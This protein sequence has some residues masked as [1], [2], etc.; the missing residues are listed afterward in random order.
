LSE[1][2]FTTVEGINSPIPERETMPVTSTVNFATRLVSGFFEWFGSLGIFSWQVLRAAVTPPF[3]GRELI[4]Q[5]DEVG[6]KSLPLVALAGAAIGAVLSMETNS[7]L[8][9]FGARSMLP[10]VTV[11]SLIVEMGPMITGLIVS[12]RVGA[13]I[14][15][16]LASMKVTEQIDAIEASAI[17]PYRLLAAT[18][19][20][21]CILMLPLLTLAADASGVLMGWV[22][23][24]L[25]EPVSL[26]RFIDSGF[27]GA[28]FN[29]FL[30]PTFKTAVFGLIIG[31]IACFQGMR[32]RGGAEGVGRA[33][34][35]AVVLSSLF[36][37]LADVVLVK[38]ILVVF[39]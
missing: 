17:N 1:S 3:E 4:R 21:A 18:R 15:A 20:L 25:V 33:A 29:A 27:R 19:I 23:Q 35:N 10:A 36:V 2:G 34:T 8:T 14:G 5:L 30:P 28:T 32:T 9:R 7:S 31:L 16:E 13:G 12:G 38:F 24:T 11:Y 26:H 6:S 39:P 37:I 22:A